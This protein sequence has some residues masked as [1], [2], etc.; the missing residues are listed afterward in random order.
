[1][2]VFTRKL[3]ALDER[4]RPQGIVADVKHSNGRMKQLG[5]TARDGDRCRCA[6]RAVKRN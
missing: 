3:H 1:M 6:R 4:S 5:K 2:D